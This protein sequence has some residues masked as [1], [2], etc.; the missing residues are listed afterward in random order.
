MQALPTSG[1]DHP[2]KG[3]LTRGLLLFLV[4]WEG[5]LSMGFQLIASRLVSPHFGASLEV[6]AWIITTFLAGFAVG[7]R[8]GGRM[9]TRPAH[10]RVRASWGLA[11][12]AV[13]AFA[14]AV[15]LRIRVPEFAVDYFDSPVTGAA[16]SCITLFFLP[17]ALLGS[18]IPL[19]I[20]SL[21]DAAEADAG[22]VAGRVYSISTA[23]NI[24]GVLGT[25]LILIPNAQLSK[26]LTCW[27]AGIGLDL[28]L[29]CHILTL[30][31]RSVHAR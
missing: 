23:G 10:Q 28:F 22:D 21:S 30:R 3:A 11:V 1:L 7:A 17:V 19:C 8:T 9:S 16:V 12:A 2:K 29:I 27:T 6:W 15:A 25:A 5:F 20:S 4:F 26:L 31:S 14:A 18:F 24:A 13:A